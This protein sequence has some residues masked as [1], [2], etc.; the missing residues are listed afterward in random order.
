MKGLTATGIPK[1]RYYRMEMESLVT[2]NFVGKIS[3]VFWF[4]AQNSSQER[5]HVKRDLQRW[6]HKTKAP[7]ELNQ[8]LGLQITWI[9]ILKHF[10]RVR[11]S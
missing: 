10:V 8:Y 1:M 7:S 2:G 4:D 6:L 11:L 5:D 3:M 9:D